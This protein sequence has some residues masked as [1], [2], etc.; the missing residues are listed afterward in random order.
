MLSEIQKDQIHFLRHGSVPH[1]EIA[2]RIHCSRSTVQRC[3]QIPWVHNKGDKRPP[4]YA[5]SCLSDVVKELHEQLLRYTGIGAGAYANLDV[6]HVDHDMTLLMAW[7]DVL[8]NKSSTN[9][10]RKHG[11][12]Q[13]RYT[14]KRCKTDPS[15]RAKCKTQ[16]NVRR[17]LTCDKNKPLYKKFQ[18]AIGCTPQ[19][20]QSHFQAQFDDRMSWANRGG[21][22][23]WQIDHIEPWGSFG[24]LSDPTNL[25]KAFHYTNLQPMWPEQNRLKS[26]GGAHCSMIKH[27]DKQ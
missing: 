24:N 20:L 15:F 19:H 5:N 3:L 9:K 1:A 14:N 21:Q 17:W 16:L 10:K 18:S 6:K 2:R 25:H 8:R 27:V 11:S 12:A 7:T 13:S 4:P 26:D 23:G 22:Q